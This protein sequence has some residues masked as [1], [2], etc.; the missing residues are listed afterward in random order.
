MMEPIPTDSAEEL[1]DALADG[2]ETLETAIEARTDD[3]EERTLESED[4]SSDVWSPRLAAWHAI[5]GERIRTG[6]EW[7]ERERCLVDA[8][9]CRQGLADVAVRRDNIAE[10][11]DHL[12]AA[13]KVFEEHNNDLY[14]DQV[15]AKK[16]ELQGVAA[17]DG[18]EDVTIVAANP[19][20][21]LPT[22]GVEGD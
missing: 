9:R 17:A 4:D 10:A 13:S 22:G 16:L 20:E 15:I 21:T 19:G 1:R 5:T 7:A 12:D 14:L 2:W 11:M 6:V 18:S 8:A 3:W